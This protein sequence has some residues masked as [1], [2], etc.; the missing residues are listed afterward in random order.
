MK[1][2]V[3]YKIGQF[4]D[5]LGNVHKF[6]IAGVS[7][8]H[9]GKESEICISE[10]D[11]YDGILIDE[12]VAAKALLIGVAICNPKD[13]FDE[14]KGKKI[15]YQK[16]INYENLHHPALYTTRPGYINT[17]V[18]DA[19]LNNVANYIT[20]DPGSVIPGYDESKKKFNKRAADAEFIAN[21]SES[22]KNLASSIKELSEEDKENLAK[23][24]N[25]T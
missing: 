8:S 23:L 6:V 2:K 20:K 17:E 24:I 16:A 4:T 19:L 15:A 1:E 21:S 7:K 5:Y 25:L 10:Y 18:V 9:P 3:S 11:L 12:E 14:E 13:T 22:L